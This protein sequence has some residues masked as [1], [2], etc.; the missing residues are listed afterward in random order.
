MATNSKW[1]C[2]ANCVPN[3]WKQT[4][5][6]SVLGELLPPAITEQILSMTSSTASAIFNSLRNQRPT[7]LAELMEAGGAYGSNPARWSAS[8]KSAKAKGLLEELHQRD[9]VGNCRGEIDPLLA[10]EEIARVGCIPT[11]APKITSVLIGEPGRKT[12]VVEG[13]AQKNCWWAMCL[14]NSKARKHP[15]QTLSAYTGNWYP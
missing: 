4:L 15:A 7:P 12:A 9:W 1:I 11:A 5:K 6:H 10:D 13:L 3:L 14:I 2:K 8:A